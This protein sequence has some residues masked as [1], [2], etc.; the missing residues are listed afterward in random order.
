LSS[1]KQSG[2]GLPDQIARMLSDR[3]PT[4][5]EAEAALLGSMMLDPS[6]VADVVEAIQDESD[7][8]RSTNGALYDII[9]TVWSQRE[10]YDLVDIHQK[11]K[12]R[13]VLDSLGGLESLVEIVESVP[14]A[15]SA[16]HYAEIVRSKSV[17]RQVIQASS[18]T[19]ESIISDSNRSVSDVLEDAESRIFNIASHSEG[20]GSSKSLGKMLEA[21]EKD[22]RE[23]QG[24]GES[25]I[26]TGFVDFD[27]M[28]GGLHEGELTL[29]AAR[30]SQG[31]SSLVL[32]IAEYLAV[33]QNIPVA[34]FSLEMSDKQL[35]DRI[36]AS[37]TGILASALRYNDVNDHDLEL[38]S[39]FS[40]EYKTCPLYVDDSPSLSPVLIRAKARR[41]KSRHKIQ[42]IFVDYIQLMNARADSRHLEISAISKGLKALAR[43]L[44]VPVVALSQLSRNVESRQNKRPIMSDLRE[45]GSLEEDA[46]AVTFLYRDDYY[47]RNE[48]AYQPDNTAEWI[49]AKQRQGPVGTAKLTWDG[50]HTKFRNAYHG[51]VPQGETVDVWD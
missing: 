7:F 8:Y 42:A 12:D 40:Q 17:Q 21:R 4:A 50:A 5:L 32:N 18:E 10:R 27:K 23:N 46:D 6:V 36:L 48:P 30:P 22:L 20:Q 9:L 34:F 44:E 26:R 47:H 15:Q 11:A 1:H 38:V 31:K 28:T 51:T 19:I 39:Q 35:A 43:E 45:S 33:D 41:L 25:G 29:I 24:T 3:V 13:G 2:G 37:R 49:V 16:R 14:H